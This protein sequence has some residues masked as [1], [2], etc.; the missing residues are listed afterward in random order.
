MEQAV[1]YQRQ[2][3]AIL[4]EIKSSGKKPR[5][6]LHACCGPCSTYVIE[7][8]VQYFDITVYFYN[9]NIHP[10]EEYEKRLSTIRRF[11]SEFPPAVQN[12]MKFVEESY[13]VQDYFSATGVLDEPELQTEG[14]R[15]ERCRRCYEFRMKKS[16]EYAENNGFDYFTTTISIS[17]CKDAK[18]I[19]EIGLALKSDKGVKYLVADFKKRNGYLRSLQLCKEYGLYRQ[20]YCGC[21]YSMQSQDCGITD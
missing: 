4:E 19:N 12:K 8:L 5:L 15:G 20:N 17:P 3:D 16:W 13:D 9:P 18:K 2:L 14:E 10:K 7:Y 11:V 1:N 21:V 6:L